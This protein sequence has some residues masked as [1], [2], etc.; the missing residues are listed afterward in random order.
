MMVSLFGYIGPGLGL[1]TIVLVLIVLFIILLSVGLIIWIPLKKFIQKILR[2][3][4][5]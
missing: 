1:G 3:P 5:E 4:K 2:R